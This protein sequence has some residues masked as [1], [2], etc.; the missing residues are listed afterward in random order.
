MTTW[1]DRLLLILIL[2]LNN[3]FFNLIM[4]QLRI[5]CMLQ[6]IQSL[7][8]DQAWRQ[9]SLLVG[10]IGDDVGIYSVFSGCHMFLYR[11]S[12]AS[13]TSLSS[14][15]FWRE[16]ILTTC[17]SRTKDRRFVHGS[18][19][20]LREVRRRTEGSGTSARREVSP[21]DQVANIQTHSQKGKWNR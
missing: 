8:H 20:R 12:A 6:V 9:A 15:H 1:F 18:R 13:R 17:T 10:S 3:L 19:T 4:S 16:A 5:C 2:P 11:L 21:A 7:I 14:G